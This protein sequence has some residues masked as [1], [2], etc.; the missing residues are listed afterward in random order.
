MTRQGML[1]RLIAL[2]GINFWY[3]LTGLSEIGG[4]IVEVGVY[5]AM[6]LY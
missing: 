4:F 1:K 3:Y 5:F 6:I 2:L